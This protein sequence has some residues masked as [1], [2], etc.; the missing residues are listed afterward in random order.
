ME[1]S[2]IKQQLTMA[3][4]LHYYG[5]KPDK[6]SRL[7][8]PFHEDKSPS[9]QVYYKTQTAYC[10][11][12]NCKTHGKSMDVID[13][14]MHQ[15]NSSKSE[16]IAKAKE[17]LGVQTEEQ[18]RVLPSTNFLG[19]MYQYFKNAV[20]NSKSAKDYLQQRG[21]DY[22]KI[23]VGYN[24]GQ[25]HHGT[26]RDEQLIAQCVERGLLLDKGQVSR[27][28][29]KA[30]GIFGKWCIVFALKNKENAIVSL[31]FRSSISDA[32]NKHYYQSRNL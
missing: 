2:E 16:A 18:S 14:V 25:F 13:F 9:M 5:L 22:K 6:H 29:E 27:T 4:V 11:S 19:G 32:N 12:S 23:E 30:Y 7:C 1:I 31:Y 10:F 21:L 28:G 20:H 26:R 17:I 3:A 24:A 8:C 15:E